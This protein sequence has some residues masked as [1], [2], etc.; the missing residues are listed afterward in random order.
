[1]GM[2]AGVFCFLKLQ[3]IIAA[4]V[5]IRI[6]IQFLAQ[7]VGVVIFRTRRKD[8][9]RP[10]KMWLY[11]LP[12]VIAFTGFVYVLISR[13]NFLKEVRYAAVL[14]VIGSILFLWRSYRR[15]EWPFR[16]RKLEVGS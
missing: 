11:P 7:T 16:N 1:M 12:A 8:V 9:E 6:I 5:V 14:I 13:N 15:K 4:L 10:F 3:D 2:A